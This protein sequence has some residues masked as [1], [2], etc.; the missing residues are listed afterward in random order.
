MTRSNHQHTPAWPLQRGATVEA[1]EC[2]ATR[3]NHPNESPGAWH[4]C[5]LCTHPWGIG[6][7]TSQEVE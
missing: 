4:T 6:L 2:G 7:H 5:N 1:C 3:E